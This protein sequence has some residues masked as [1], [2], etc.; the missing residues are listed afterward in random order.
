MKDGPAG[1]LGF[2]QTESSVIAELIT[3]FCDNKW[4]TLFRL[5]S[6]I[7][8]ILEAPIRFSRSQNTLELRFKSDTGRKPKYLADFY[9]AK[10]WIS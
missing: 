2:A 4:I 7:D 8:D 10:S 3:A 1:N 5:E 6:N 9:D